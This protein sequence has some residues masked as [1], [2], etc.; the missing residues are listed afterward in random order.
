MVDHKRFDCVLTSS[1][2]P[3][4]LASRGQAGLRS[5]RR[6]MNTRDYAQTNPIWLTSAPLHAIGVDTGR[7]L[8]CAHHRVQRRTKRAGQV[9]GEGGWWREVFGGTV[10]RQQARIPQREALRCT[11]LFSARLGNEEGRERNDV[12]STYVATE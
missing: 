3:V 7:L 5:R 8:R 6:K 10:R 11:K 2:L 12:W 4:F 9:G 1:S